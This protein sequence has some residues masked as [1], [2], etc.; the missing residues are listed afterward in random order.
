MFLDKHVPWDHYPK[1]LSFDE[2]RN[3]HWVIEQFF[4]WDWPQGH[5]ED[6]KTWRR[7]VVA[8]ESYNDKRLGAGKLLSRYHS[9]LK[10][11]EALYILRLINS[12]EPIE[13]VSLTQLQSER[14]KWYWMPDNLSDDE[15]TDPYRLLKKFFKTTKPQRCRDYLLE[16]IDFAL[17]PQPID[18]LSA[19]EVIG[20]Y[21]NLK[22][23]IAVAWLIRQREGDNPVYKPHEKTAITDELIENPLTHV[24]LSTVTE[25]DTP[26]ERLVLKNSVAAILDIAPAIKAIIHIGTVKKPHTIMLYVM[27]DEFLYA[28]NESLDTALTKTIKSLIPILLIAESSRILR[29]NN[30]QARG[31]LSYSIGKGNIL[32]EASNISLKHI[33]PKFQPVTLDAS[34]TAQ[35][36][37]TIAH[38]HFLQSDYDIGKQDL[39]KAMRSMSS[40]IIICLE[41]LLFI[42][43]GYKTNHPDIERL[44]KMTM[45]LTEEIQ[46]Q[47][48]MLR[49][50]HPTLYPA[51]ITKQEAVNEIGQ[52]LT[53]QNIVAFREEL[54]KL[55]VYIINLIN[56]N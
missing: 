40:S 36:N 15:L 44:I 10:L 31:F 12:Q 51:L 27:A 4:D 26:A 28:V 16:W 22:K 37:L 48:E 41:T 5:L 34:A 47:F 17:S 56:S 52:E 3:P 30:D 7:F 8:Y 42:K 35:N 24:K 50:N 45:L 23:L 46:I 9:I 49:Q 43:T 2:I 39:P 32:Y 38:A 11:L 20:F 33:G 53:T 13:A 29:E 19:Q 25:P 55:R 18:S 14:D 21:K 1:N 54:N 6:L